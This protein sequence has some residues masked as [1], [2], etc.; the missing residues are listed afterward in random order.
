MYLKQMIIRFQ[1]RVPIP[2]GKIGGVGGEHF[3]QRWNDYVQRLVTVSA[4]KAN[5]TVLKRHILK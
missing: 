1:L 2:K 3:G 5:C 4:C